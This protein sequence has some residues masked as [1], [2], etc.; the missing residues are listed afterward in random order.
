[1][2][3]T[4]GLVTS[5]FWILT[6]GAIALFA[7]FAALGSFSPGEV[8]WLSVAVGI[9]AIAALIHF[10]RVRRA[11]GDHRHDE[12]ARRVHAMREHRGF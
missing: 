12:L 4:V 10:L 11:L 9:L 1:M 6:L 7:F 8:A 3:K 5:L 2:L